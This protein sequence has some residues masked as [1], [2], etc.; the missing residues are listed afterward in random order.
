MAPKNTARRHEQAKSAYNVFAA[1]CP[2]H[3]LFSTVSDK[4]V[5]LVLV[6]LAEG[7]R[8]HGELEAAIAG[9]SGST[10]TRT[11]RT[12][13]RDGLVTRT[14][15]VSVPVRGAFALTALGVSLLPVLRAVQNW[16]E[17]HMDDVVDARTTYD[18]ANPPADSAHA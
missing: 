17:T 8:P 3:R 2:T 15:T 18:E 5:G 14:V 6:A 1:L 7:S 13:E 12:L 10:L 16:A 11:L 4:W 9:I